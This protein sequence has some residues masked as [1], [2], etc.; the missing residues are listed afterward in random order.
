M[1]F[2]CSVLAS[3]FIIKHSLRLKVS[4]AADTDKKKHLAVLASVFKILNNYF[5]KNSPP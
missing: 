2:S 3:F 4:T 5:K 1:K